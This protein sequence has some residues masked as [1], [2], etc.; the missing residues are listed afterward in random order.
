MYEDQRVSSTDLVVLAS[1]CFRIDQYRSS[2]PIDDPIP[3]QLV[4]PPWQNCLSGSRIFEICMILF[5]NYKKKKRECTYGLSL[6]NTGYSLNVSLLNFTWT[7]LQ[8]L[9]STCSSDPFLKVIALL[10][11]L[12]SKDF[13]ALDPYSNWGCIFRLPFPLLPLALEV[14]IVS[15]VTWNNDELLTGPVVEG[16][17]S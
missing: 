7:D 16:K 1:S 14:G 8:A 3:T 2:T 11:L 13:T 17:F 6:G 5:I 4:G 15:S 12:S 9:E 10:E